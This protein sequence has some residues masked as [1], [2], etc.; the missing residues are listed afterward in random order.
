MTEKYSGVKNSYSGK[1]LT[2]SWSTAHEDVHIIGTKSSNGTPVP[3]LL[4]LSPLIMQLEHWVEKH[5]QRDNGWSLNGGLASSR[6][7]LLE[8]PLCGFSHT[9]WTR[10]WTWELFYISRQNR[11]FSKDWGIL[12]LAS[13]GP[14]Y[15]SHANFSLFFQTAHMFRNSQPFQ[16]LPH[17]PLEERLLSGRRMK[18]LPHLKPLKRRFQLFLLDL[19]TL[20]PPQS[21]WKDLGILWISDH[22]VHEFQHQLRRYVIINCNFISTYVKITK[23][24]S[25][26]S[27]NVW[28]IFNS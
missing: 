6:R 11:I 14:R 24:Q 18:E 22:P 27:L 20:D 10:A 26:G 8:A 23:S 1:T 16:D 4:R 3:V 15:N 5:S 12:F 28:W 7:K 19:N 13:I 9:I 25:R 17:Q 21:R 2:T